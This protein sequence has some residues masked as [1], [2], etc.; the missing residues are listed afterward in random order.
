M[1]ALIV[2]SFLALSWWLLRIVK[3]YRT[4][5]YRSA[6]LQPSL[7]VVLLLAL[8]WL[9]LL[10]ERTSDV[11]PKGDL[12]YLGDHLCWPYNVNV[13][14]ID[15]WEM[16]SAFHRYP[17]DS[18]FS[19]GEEFGRTRW[20]KYNEIDTAV[21]YGM[22][23]TLKYCVGNTDLYNS[24]LKG[25]PIYFAGTYRMVIVANGSKKRDYER[26]L[27]LDVTNDR[28]HIFKDIDKVF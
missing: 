8:A 20:T 18:Y 1:Y 22:D 4:G 11:L 10:F 17:L 15:E 19:E 25:H 7:L 14:S 26:I 23:S 9:Y 21:W 13:Y 6:I 24:L 16:D 2:I 3:A 12:L 28:I 5:G 27:F